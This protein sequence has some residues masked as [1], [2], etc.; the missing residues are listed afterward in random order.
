[1]E[2]DHPA[3][4]VGANAINP[5]SVA[6]NAVSRYYNTCPYPIY[7]VNTLPGFASG[8]SYVAPGAFTVMQWYDGVI[9]DV[10]VCVCA[11]PK[12]PVVQS[13]KVYV[14]PPFGSPSF[15]CIDSTVLV[16][17]F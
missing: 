13:G 17:D 6:P 11:A 10:H 12:K 4:I 15:E 3:G 16:L 7:A 1:M 5:G 9:R 14:N 2:E 8:P